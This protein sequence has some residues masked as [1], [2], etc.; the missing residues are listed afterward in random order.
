MAREENKVVYYCPICSNETLS[1][2]KNVC[3]CCLSAFDDKHIFGFIDCD[4]CASKDSVIYDKLNIHN[5]GSHMIRGLCLYFFL[6]NI[7]QM[8]KHLI[9]VGY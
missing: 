5:D 8:M 4:F 6:L 3:Y 9:S 7:P 2:N 1:E